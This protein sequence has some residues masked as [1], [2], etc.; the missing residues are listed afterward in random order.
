MCQTFKSA[1]DVIVENY[2]PKSI[3]GLTMF[4][5]KVNI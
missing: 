3:T 2:V 4:S 5:E 1:Y